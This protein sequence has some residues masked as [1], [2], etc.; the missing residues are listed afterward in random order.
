MKILF[1]NPHGLEV[2]VSTPE[3]E[4]L[5]GIVSSIC[6]LARQL[7]HSGH[8]VTLLSNL[9][10]DTP[11]QLLGVHHVPLATIQTEGAAFFRAR[12]YDAAIVANGPELAPHI[13]T[14]SPKPIILLG[15]IH[16]PTSRS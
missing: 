3:R 8:N 7:A 11:A 14:A 6:Y 1:I 2:N 12:D 13:K 4:P 10:K 16:F 15:C 9:P 5:G